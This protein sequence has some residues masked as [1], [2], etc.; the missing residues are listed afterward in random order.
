[1]GMM[2]FG[3]EKTNFQRESTNNASSENAPIPVKISST[4]VYIK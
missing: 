1:M 2:R 3:L 4:D